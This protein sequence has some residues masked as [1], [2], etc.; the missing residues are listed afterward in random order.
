MVDARLRQATIMKAVL[1][2]LFALAVPLLAQTPAQLKQELRTKESAAKKDPEALC[3]L[4]QWATEKGLT[5]EAKRIYLAVLKLK[6]DHEGANLGLGNM[7]FDGKWLPAKEAEALRRKAEAADYAA[8]G[9]VEVQGVWV[10]KEQADDAKLGIFHHENQIVSKEEKLALMRGFIR[11]PDTDELI[12][13]KFAEKAQAHLYPIGSPVKWVD[14]K[15]AD[16]Y[17]SDIKRPW[18]VR[19]AYCTVVSTYP[20]AKISELKQQVDRGYECSIR[21]LGDAP[22]LPAHR[23]VVIIATTQE[24]FREYGTALGD[25]TSAW[26]AFL[27]REEATISL[28]YSGAIRGAV[29]DGTGPLGPYNVRDAAG[30]A[31]AECKFAQDGNEAP[32]WIRHGVGTYASRFE[33]KSLASFY[34]KNH[35]KRGGVKN[36]KAFFASFAINGDMESEELIHNTYQAGLLFDF[37]L[38]GGDAPTTAALTGLVEALSSHKKGATDKAAEKLQAALIAAEA[39]VAAHL[40]KLTA[41]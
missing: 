35:L 18:I 5:S 13:P 15:E 14:E 8:K 2:A 40:Q 10:T 6:P 24:E 16:K 29:C 26:G 36:L 39:K 9:M 3:A 7:L 23:P 17:H 19:S 12:D 41:N 28:P 37:A 38:D 21:L 33:N 32:L 11:H 30:I 31:V 34:G 1:A 22:L 27:M 25:E 4:G 20:I